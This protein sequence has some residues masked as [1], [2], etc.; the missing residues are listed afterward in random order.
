MVNH[1]H[2]K[3]CLTLSVLLAGIVWTS[4]SA[5]TYYVDDSAPGSNNGSTWSNAYRSLQTALTNAGSGDLIYVAQG[6]YAPYDPS[7][8][9]RSTFQ[10]KNGVTLKGGYA[11][12]MA[13][14]PMARD[15]SAY[16]STLTGE[17]GSANTRSD[18]IYHVVTGSGCDRTAVLDGFT[19]DNGN[20]NGSD[21]YDCGG[22]IYNRSGSP[23]IRNCTIK[24][25]YAKV[26]GAGMAN[27]FESHPMV[28]NCV[29]F[30]NETSDFSGGGMDNFYNS[31]PTV[32]NC[33]FSQNTA[34][35]FGG[36]MVNG[37][38]SNPRLINCV[39]ALNSVEWEHSAGGGISNSMSDPSLYNCLFRLNRAGKNGG[40]MDNAY[41]SP[42]ITNC[43][44]KDNT[45]ANEGGG[46]RTW[47]NSHPVVKNCIFWGNSDRG[48]TDESAQIHTTSDSHIDVDYSCVQGLR[49]SLGG[50][51]NI[52][53]NPGFADI[54]GRLSFGSACIDTGDNSAVP[55][56]ITT[57]LD[58]NPRIVDGIVDMGAYEFDRAGEIIYV[59][60]DAPGS[61]HDCSSW[62]T[63]C[64]ELT[65][66]LANAISG[67][68]IHV[69]QGVYRPFGL[70]SPREFTFQL[71]KGVTIKG[72]YAG[73]GESNPDARNIQAYQTILS[74]DIL[75][76]G[77]NPDNCYHVVTA[78]ECPDTTILDGFTI[79][80]GNADGQI[81]GSDFYLYGGGMY[82][83]GGS[84]KVINCTFTDNN[85]H[86][87]GDGLFTTNCTA[88]VK[89]CTF[90]QNQGQGIYNDDS[91]LIVSG[92]TFNGNLYEAMF[93][94]YSNGKVDGCTFSQNA[95]GI[96]NHTSSPEVT[97]CTFS[98]HTGNGGMVNIYSSNPKIINCT[99]S[100]NSPGR[101]MS[102]TDHSSPRVINCIFRGNQQEGGGGGM[103]NHDQ[104]NPTI[105]NCAFLN[106]SAITHVGV[107]FI[108]PGD[109]GGIHNVQSNP[110]VYNCTFKGNTAEEDGGGIFNYE[111]NPRLVNCI[112][113]DNRDAGGT[114]ESAQIHNEQNSRPTINHSCVQSWS[115]TLGG[116][117]NFRSNPQFSDTD[118]RLSSN[119][120]CIDAGDNNAVPSD[121]T[122]DLDGNLRIINH[123]VD[124][125]AYEFGGSTTGPPPAPT[126][127]TIT[128]GPNMGEIILSWNASPRATGYQIYYDEDTSNPPF[129]PTQNGNPASGS[130]VGNVTQVTIS[131]LSPG[132]SYCFAV[133]AH[134]AAGE[135]DYS[136]QQCGRSGPKGQGVDLYD[137]G[138]SHRRFEPRTL[139]AGR[140][141]QS[142][143]I[144][145][146]IQN[147]G[148][149]SSSTCKVSFHLSTDTNITPSDY[150]IGTKETLEPLEPGGTFSFVAT[151]AFPTSIPSGSY[152][153][154]WIIDVDNDIDET[155]E[156][157][158]TA[159]KQGYQLNVT[160][161]DIG[162]CD[163]PYSP[164]DR[165]HLLV[166]NP[167]G[168]EGLIA[169][170]TGTVICCDYDDPELPVF[171]SWDGW[172]NGRNNDGY[173]DT[174]I[175]PYP[176]NSGW[177]MACN[178]IAPGDSGE[179]AGCCDP[180]FSPGDR[181]KLL[182]SYPRGATGLA[183]GRLG[184]VICCDY[185]D[186]DLPVFVSWD[187]WTN[188]RNSDVYCDTSI[189]PYPS[190]S[191]WWMAC[192]EIEPSSVLRRRPNQ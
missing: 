157:N 126:G 166:N 144:Y 175:H 56:D 43:T 130:D 147:G 69:A 167:R 14:D 73:Y 192:D 63:A 178:Q 129:T 179:G 77:S 181:V 176:A 139:Q 94:K 41:C 45:A 21:P 75:A 125:G 48:G 28:S 173:C 185:D 122:T 141:G 51:G 159:Y 39:F 174:S 112:L 180:S 102:N 3:I 82:I 115:G 88:E 9:R 155:N 66:A 6:L 44:F 52:S 123:I 80:G 189:Y 30:R 93:N 20:A 140:S 148:T 120:P 31:S 13:P 8:P 143:K 183:A 104:S 145:S 49:S 92:C 85:A 79:T 16:R 59:D 70:G 103:F 17:I 27:Q 153:V 22:G 68:E 54:E 109:G 188:G 11:G 186:P 170:M 128:E 4:A 34:F 160:S 134:N 106:N 119:S 107:E 150:M 156:Q 76:R 61:Q 151:E 65:T 191:G 18:N 40:G 131:G 142:L 163:P 136:E 95:S 29:F 127:I 37:T 5:E 177:W 113:W 83:K 32:I 135:S 57:D 138:E 86:K 64:T 23:T 124:L 7:S 187:A 168:A 137:L 47:D 19:I 118:G 100:D 72:G 121:V 99:F 58:R 105:V 184:T 67:D 152:Y 38:Y 15:W 171:V 89:D 55:S 78:E 146:A 97:H 10:L 1:P 158:N 35:T 26:G 50:T 169:G 164:G 172:T 162:C 33:I 114:N 154:G 71:V 90:Q 84:P 25:N 111:S 110:L 36:G 108:S 42:L 96:R 2:S 132:E 60:A 117:A 182:V 74:G 98:G 161:G 81:N 62:A 165:V 149:E 101:G 116:N 24:Y 12:Y 190:N 53:T 87:G 91:D 46:I 133:R